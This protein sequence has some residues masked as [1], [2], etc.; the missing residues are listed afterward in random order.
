[1]RVTLIA[2]LL[3]CVFMLAI[4]LAV[5]NVKRRRM[6]RRREQLQEEAKSARRRGGAEVIMV[7]V[8]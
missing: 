2:M 5:E 7:A 6:R 3:L 8:R 4:Y 1:M